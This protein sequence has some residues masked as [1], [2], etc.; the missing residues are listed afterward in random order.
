MCV[1]PGHLGVYIGVNRLLSGFHLP[2]YSGCNLLGL[3]G[4]ICGIVI[5]SLRVVLMSMCP[6][7]GGFLGC[8][9][10]HVR[11]IHCFNGFP[12]E[13]CLLRFFK[14]FRFRPGLDADSDLLLRISGILIPLIN[15]GID[16]VI[17]LSLISEHGI[18]DWYVCD[19][20]PCD[21]NP[22]L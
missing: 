12:E 14:G 3:P 15:K 19:T 10:G 18:R 7:F 9:G 2:W 5:F 20:I 16:A 6:S 13:L 22:G 11:F 4:V 1:K 17:L 21:S 8:S